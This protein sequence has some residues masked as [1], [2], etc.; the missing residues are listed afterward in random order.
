MKAA[1]APVVPEQPDP[2]TK[3]SESE[4]VSYMY[5]NHVAD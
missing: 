4:S 5:F 3:A 1:H 2:E